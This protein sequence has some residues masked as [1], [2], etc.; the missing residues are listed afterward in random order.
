METNSELIKI[1]QLSDSAFPSGAFAFSGGL[2]SLTREWETFSVEDLVFVLKEQVIPRWFD[3]D[4]VF[5]RD[6]YDCRENIEKV[7]DVD[8]SCHLQNTN[9]SLAR[10][11]RRIG[12][13]LLS[14]HSKMGTPGA[15]ALSNA[16]PNLGEAGICGYEPVVRG[17]VGSALKIE[18]RLLEA[19]SAYGALFSVLSSA[20]RLNVVGSIQ[21]QQIMTN[22]SSVVAEKLS[23]ETPKVA[24]NN[25]LLMDIAASRQ[26]LHDVSLFSN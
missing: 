21:A 17:F 6:A 4:R 26:N 19:G 18:L 14:V 22:L 25:T 2:E 1:F 7:V 12:R 23:T 15:S 13:S 5:V 10:A 16:L 9:A 8:K 11:S 20:I 24:T 3:F